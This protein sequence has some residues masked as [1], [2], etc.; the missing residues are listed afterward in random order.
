MALARLGRK[1]F[2]SL[3]VSL[4]GQDLSEP[5]SLEESESQLDPST[6]WSQ[7]DVPARPRRPW[8]GS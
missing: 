6:E 5:P 2:I 7:E 8:D 1:A 3:Y 4:L